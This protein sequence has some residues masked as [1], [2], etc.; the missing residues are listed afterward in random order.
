MKRAPGVEA[1]SRAS[2]GA[3]LPPRT[4]ESSRRQ[5]CQPAGAEPAGDRCAPLRTLLQQLQKL[6]TLVTS[7]I[8]RPYKMAATQTGT[9]LMVGYC[10]LPTEPQEA[11]SP[12]RPAFRGPGGWCAELSVPWLQQTPASFTKARGTFWNM[13]FPDQF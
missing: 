4:G 12:P 5:R 11:R 2:P 6:Q 10:S 7:K 13:T 3:P 1:K 8:S 9:C